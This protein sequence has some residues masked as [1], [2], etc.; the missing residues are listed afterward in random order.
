[1][2]SEQ[3]GKALIY[4]LKNTKTVKLDLKGHEKSK[5]VSCIEFK[6]RYRPS[7]SKESTVTHEEKKQKAIAD[8]A[9]DKKS[10]RKITS[11]E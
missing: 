1:M 4:D 7:S 5:R 11:P 10:P 6:R 9:V 3:G 8:V 2:G